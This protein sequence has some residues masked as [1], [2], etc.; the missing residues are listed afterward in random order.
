MNLTL[1]TKAKCI[2]RNFAF[3]RLFRMEKSYDMVFG[4]V[5]KFEKHEI[6]LQS[7]INENLKVKFQRTECKF[8][9]LNIS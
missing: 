6:K 1:F 9:Y 8:R 4:F 5:Q 7:N 3:A 2:S